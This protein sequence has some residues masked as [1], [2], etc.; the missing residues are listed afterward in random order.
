[1]RSPR[2]L[3]Y[4]VLAV[5]L[6]IAYSS[7]TIADLWTDWMWFE[8]VNQGPVFEKVFFVQAGLGLGFGL[9]VTA[10]LYLNGAVALRGA[11]DRPVA[12][13]RGNP[14]GSPA[15]PVK[16][17]RGGLIAAAL[18]IGA[19]HGLWAT[20]RWARLL[21]A[22]HGDTF[23]F[24]EPI[25]SLDA[26]FYVFILPLLED[27]R[28]G[29]LSTTVFS[30]IVSGAVYLARGAVQVEMAM[31]DGRP[32]PNGV[33][34]SDMVRN[35]A[36][37]LA[38]VVL[39]LIATSLY[40][41]RFTV[42]YDPSGLM[43]GP[44]YSDV[45]GRLPLLTAQ[46][47]ATA[48]AALLV[49]IG[50]ARK[51]NNLIL[52]GAG[53][54]AAAWAAATVYPDLLQRFSVLP[55]ELN[56]EAPFIVH[57]VDA[58][59][60]AFDLQ[61]VD[62]RW[63]S[64]DH[65][66]DAED[67]ANNQPTIVNVRLWDHA[68]LLNTF[69]QVQEIRTYYDFASVDNDRYMI[70]G[71]LRQTMLSPRELRS[72]SLP[73]QARTWVNE[74]MT[75][76]HGY[77]MALGPV[78]EVTAEG[79]PELFVQDL[80]PQILYPDDLAIDRPEIYFGESMEQAVFVKTRN[81]EFDYPS[82]EKNRY[83]VYS[84]EGGIS[85]GTF[86]HQLL[87]SVR[88]RTALVLLS[89]DLQA[90]SRVLLYR[91]ALHRVMRVAPFLRYDHDPY[92]AV[93]DGRLVWIV[94]AYTTSF[95]F[96]YSQQY[97]RSFGNYMRNAVKA[98]VDAYDG[99]VTLYAMDEEDPILAAW[100]SAFPD[101]F[102]P[103]DQMPQGIR[104]HLRYPQDYF[105]A[106]ASLFATYHMTNPQIFYNREDEWEVPQVDG[107]RMTPYYTIMRLPGE[108]KEEFILMLPFVPR[109]KPNLAA[110]MVA[111]SDGDAYGSMRVY[112]FPKDKMVY[113]PNMIVARINQDDTI[114]EKLSLWG[115]QG[116]NVVLGTLLV[117]PIEES[118]IYVQP[119]YLKA[120][121]GSIPELKRVIVG[122]ENQISM[123][124]TLDLALEQLFGAAKPARVAESAPGAGAPTGTSAPPAS[125]SDDLAVT[126]RAHYE[127][128]QRAAA[129]GDWTQ[130]GAELD[131][132]GVVI[133][134]LATPQPVAAEEDQAEAPPTAP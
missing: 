109:D 36:G 104:D 88:L 51:R 27:L 66:L 77:G 47:L 105:A 34:A 9:F 92:M 12:V 95:R 63:L 73:P 29:L 28:S 23:D 55:N 116:S 59:R 48:A 50:L 74:T 19:L 13:V 65:D 11:V 40:L 86:W 127:A 126:A 2:A 120:E 42:L 81:E 44:T 82:G 31:V 56:L 38:G 99:T 112:K 53:A 97:N 18:A 114:S 60:R 70:D 7:G 33:R 1:M 39:L 43:G 16:M 71:Q 89:D 130:F 80:P 68:P 96:P 93:V 118:L 30:I 54:A 113:G 22:W 5:V 26:S 72:Q 128:A 115:T 121:S 58:T 37:V 25:Y 24:S 49:G 102:T 108:A 35:H 125:G 15:V 3:I 75:Y 133:E 123:E 131:A 61:N 21:L 84:G 107:I 103:A 57:H 98:T 69:S 129:A 78:N 91:N 32:M 20:S 67:I 6:G 52:T 8:S 132:L 100:S 64:G 134:L 41:T 110:W 79:L 4:L 85:V 117:I 14:A 122:Y 124:P 94:D 87:V 46:A 111:R 17:M 76:T 106:Q 119:L 83:T 10:F 101:M 90:E 62:E 45:Y